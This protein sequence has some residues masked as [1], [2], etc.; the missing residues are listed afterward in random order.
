MIVILVI[1]IIVIVIL[2]SHN[3]EKNCHYNDND[4]DHYHYAQHCSLARSCCCD[5]MLMKHSICPRQDFSQQRERLAYACQSKR[6]R[7]R[8]SI[9]SSSE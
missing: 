3:D 2:I 7:H 8:K 9:F 6:F 1:I 4:I 5:F